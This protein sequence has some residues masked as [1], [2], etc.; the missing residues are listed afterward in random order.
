M[1]C[2][3]CLAVATT[4]CSNPCAPANV[5]RNCSV[6]DATASTI[7]CSSRCF[8]G[9]R[10]TPGVEAAAAAA[11][12]PI[13]IHP[14][15]TKATTKAPGMSNMV[16]RHCTAPPTEP[17]TRES[18]RAP[19]CAATT[20]NTPRPTMDPRRRVNAA[21]IGEFLFRM[22]RHSH[23][24]TTARGFVRALETHSAF[25]RRQTI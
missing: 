16:G 6:H 15:R 5:S 2:G 4:A 3:A 20:T 18:P 17:S 22:F 10:P 24:A 11:A 25:H 7:A 9:R 19:R 21:F 23:C 8:T 12:A 14:V 1:G 13:T